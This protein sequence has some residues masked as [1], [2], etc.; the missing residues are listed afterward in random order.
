MKEAVIVIYRKGSYKFQGQSKGSTGWFNLDN[1]FLKQ[2]CYTLELDFY[3][4]LYEKDIEGQNM[5]P[6]KTFLVPFDTNK[7]NLFMRNG[8]VKNREKNIASYYDE[9][10][11]NS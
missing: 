7:L 3:K 1:E 2:K 4:K 11:K 6:Y 8:P 10:P 9:A 5:E